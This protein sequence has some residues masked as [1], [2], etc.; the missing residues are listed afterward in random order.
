M[1]WAQSLLING[2]CFCWSRLLTLFQLIFKIIVFNSWI[3]GKNYIT[4]DA[5]EKI[6]PIRELRQGNEIEVI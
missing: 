1:Y 2:M 6:P 3:C 5:I 4:P